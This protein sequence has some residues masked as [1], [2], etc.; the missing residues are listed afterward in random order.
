MSNIPGKGRNWYDFLERT[1][2][3]GAQN[4]E[5]CESLSKRI[6]LL[7]SGAGFPSCPMAPRCKYREENG[8]PHR[9]SV[10]SWAGWFLHALTEGH[11][12]DNLI[13]TKKGASSNPD[14]HGTKRVQTLPS[15]DRKGKLSGNAAKEHVSDLSG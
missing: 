10:L 3:T 4:L 12:G 7:T 6:P 2:L 11:E 15:E 13:I 8:R 9:T 14:E 5:T 1:R